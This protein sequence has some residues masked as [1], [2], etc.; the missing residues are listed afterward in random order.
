MRKEA[1]DDVERQEDTC[2]VVENTINVDNPERLMD[3]AHAERQLMFQYLVRRYLSQ[4]QYGCEDSNCTTP[5]CLSCKKRLTSKPFRVPT[6][7]TAR[8]I[9]HYLASQDNPYAGLCCNTPKVLP[10]NLEIAM[11]G[12]PDL[13]SLQ[14]Q[15]QAKK[16]NKS[17]GQNVF[18]T[19]SV[20]FS[21]SKHIPRAIDVFN[22]LPELTEE[23]MNIPQGHESQLA[24]V[25][26]GP[27]SPTLSD[28]SYNASARRPRSPP[29]LA[30]QSMANGHADTTCVNGHH[31]TNLPETERRPSLSKDHPVAG[32]KKSQKQASTDSIS[33]ILSDG[34][35]VQLRK[36]RQRLPQQLTNGQSDTRTDYYKGFDGTE[37]NGINHSPAMAKR[38]PPSLVPLE[39]RRKAPYPVA[40]S[41]GVTGKESLKSSKTA[42]PVIS[43]L[44][45]DIM[46]DLANHTHEGNLE[47]EP[48]CHS[49]MVYDKSARLGGTSPFVD[50]S[51]YYTLSDPDTLLRSFR[52]EPW[53]GGNDSPLPHLNSNRLSHAF[54]SWNQRNG[55][56]IFDSLWI[57]ARSLFTSP[58]EV[59]TQKSPRLRAAQKSPERNGFTAHTP[60]SPSHNDSQSIFLS[61]LDASHIVMICIHALTSLVPTGWP[62]AWQE[63]RKLRSWGV[64]IP[65]HPQQTQDPGYH[66]VHPWL[67]IIDELEYEPAFRLADR[68]VRGIGAR[69]CF[70]EILR[71]LSSQASEQQEDLREYAF[72]LTSILIKH[73]TVVE[74]QA[75]S[76]R[77]NLKTDTDPGWTVTSVFLEWLR[78]L[79]IKSWDG[80]PEIHRWSAVGGAIEI[81]ADLYEH[82][83]DLNLY[84]SMFCIPYL[85]ERIDQTR[86]PTD[87]LN[88]SP[89]P[90][91]L[92]LLSYPFL[93]LPHHLVS[94]FRTVNYE[95]MYRQYEIAERTIHLRRQLNPFLNDQFWW[96]TTRCLKIPLGHYLVLDV[97]RKN[98]LQDAFDQLWGLERRQFLKPLKVKMG[99]SEGEVGVDQGGVSLEF[100]RVILN[101]VF[102]TDNGMFA[103]DP[104][105]RMTWFQPASLEPIYRFELVGI[106]FSLAIY[107]GVTLPITFPKAFYRRILDKPVTSIRH[108]RDGWPEL[109]RSFEQLLSWS[110]GDVG[111]I[112]VRTYAFSFES[113][114]QRVDVDME[115]FEREELWPADLVD[116]GKT[117]LL[118]P[119][120]AANRS[121][122]PDSVPLPEVT[123][124]AWE[125]PER[126]SVH[127]LHW[128]S[129]NSDAILDWVNMNVEP[130]SDAP[131]RS[132]GRNVSFTKSREASLVTNENRE[133]FVD[134]YIFWLTD[135][136]VRPQFEAFKKGFFTCLDKTA[137]Q[138]FN[139]ESLQTL[140]EGHQNIL[141][142]E[143]KEVTRYEDGYTANHPLI[144]DFWA[145][146]ETF[147]AE[148]KRQLLEF[149]T[150]SDRLP[151]SGVSSIQFCIVRATADTENLPTS[152]TCFG[153]LML[154]EY[155]GK[156]KLERKLRL[157]MQNSKGFGSA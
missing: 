113:L 124:V 64:I 45:C 101:E 123:S 143:L 107:N 47:K 70:S 126:R 99:A 140:V 141:I 145:L 151:V 51:L 16:D 128:N 73:L 15:R 88:R 97:S 104:R 75:R 60:T 148:E 106:L 117:W 7:V 38:H 95:N 14:D 56:L 152:S 125:R 18:D 94:Y 21:Y 24:G 19:L 32:V 91:T 29:M 110:D 109:A 35:K 116:G 62:H 112:F 133:R 59:V 102:N 66:Y 4:I 33:E 93:F 71:T 118:S 83:D 142:P 79:I 80:K 154:P 90:N 31:S 41:N 149:V 135:K 22:R 23:M 68:L 65:Q 28:P 127:P 108:I 157:A 98:P 2:R 115:A 5:T 76:S 146:V 114:G 103:I 147:T 96:G 1:Q 43:H 27:R 39:K 111:D 85:H 150:A 122:W 155:S 139:A 89:N 82:R 156:E 105:T 61:D 138:L 6:P 69:R 144:L 84:S 37:E 136:S 46:D 81:M 131:G 8:T 78:T 86:M 17:L 134:D 72:G 53:K 137:L 20:I 48:P 34:Q 42:L 87:F 67:S 100:F 25:N 26:E 55:S 54:R 92:H 121:T 40:L 63:V 130:D 13:S 12:Q 129:D 58:P 49:F 52:E 9:A 74:R 120:L 10:S 3:S 44:S 153:K 11:A 132:E 36:I 77:M 30:P 50:R 119:S 57:A